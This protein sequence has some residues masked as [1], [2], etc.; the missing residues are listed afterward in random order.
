MNLNPEA[1]DNFSVDAW[2]DSDAGGIDLTVTDSATFDLR[3]GGNVIL[4]VKDLGKSIKFYNEV[5][6]LPI[7]DQRET[8]VDLGTSGPS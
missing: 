1:I 7:K 2:S 5:I 4:A 3:N 8:W 6:G